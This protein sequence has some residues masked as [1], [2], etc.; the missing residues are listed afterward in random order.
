MTTRVVNVEVGVRTAQVV[1]VDTGPRTITTLVTP[2]EP[3]IR[4]ISTALL[5]P[6]GPQ[7]ELGPTGLSAYEVALLEGFIGTEAEWLESLVG[8]QGATGGSYTH[9]QGSTAAV[10]TVVHN[11]GYRPNVRTVDTLDRPVI[12]DV[13][14]ID[15]NSLTITFVVAMSGKAY[16]S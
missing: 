7:G 9:V 5:G 12:G 15:T 14:D 13:E 8:P 10:W 2:A 3:E 1:T 6:R 16:L 4:I 11:L